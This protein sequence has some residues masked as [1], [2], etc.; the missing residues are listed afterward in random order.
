[1]E[2]EGNTEE[3]RQGRR[4]NISFQNYSARR[5]SNWDFEEY[6]NVY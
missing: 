6:K 3:R 2:Q 4:Y 5:L 1:M